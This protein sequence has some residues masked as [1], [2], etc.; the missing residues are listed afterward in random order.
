MSTTTALM[1]HLSQAPAETFDAYMRRVFQAPMLSAEE[2]HQLATRVQQ[3]NDLD[4]AKQLILSHLRLVAHLA[5]RYQHF[6]LA[7]SD[8]V[9]EGTVGLMKAVKRFKPQKGV[10]LASFAMQ[11]IKSEIY[12]FVVKNWRIVK[13]ATTKAE[14][15]LFTNLHRF[16]IMTEEDVSL[17]AQTLSV[18]ERD[19]HAMITKLNQ[20]HDIAFDEPDHDNHSTWS[21][22]HYLESTNISP[23]QAAHTDES[24]QRAAIMI[25]Q[26]LDLLD[27]RS[28]I[29]IEKRWFHDEEKKPSLKVI[30]DELGISLER[31]RQI[32]RQGFASMQKHLKDNQ[33]E[34]H[35]SL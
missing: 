5:Y 15:K 10:R 23:E 33:V 34:L 17:V 9:Q 20:H 32:E 29:V 26:G 27:P 24:Q 19:V 30:A 25:R 11:W 22:S 3:D 1:T 16:T 28:R 31:V 18:K 13:I 12:D 4:A 2:E 7:M 35:A 6:G 14:R 8:L 21:P